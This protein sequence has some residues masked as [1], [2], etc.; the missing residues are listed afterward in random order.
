[1]LEGSL[2]PTRP[3]ATFTWSIGW[4]CVLL[5]CALAQVAGSIACKQ[6]ASSSEKVLRVGIL[7]PF[8][9]PAARTGEE[10]KDSVQMA[11]E[12]I[13]YRIG[14]YKVELRWIDEESDPQ[15]AVTNY[16][17]A[18][19][20][21]QIEVG[22]LNWHS[23]VAVAVMEVT[24]RY[25]IP[26]FFGM[27][28]TEV[29]NEKYRSDPARYSYWMAKGWPSPSKLTLAYVDALEDAIQHARWNL[30]AKTAAIWGEDTDWGRAFGQAIRDQ[31]QAHGWTIVAEEYFPLGETDFY[32][33]LLKF[34][35]ERVALLAGTST[36]PSS[37]S[38]FIKQTREV[39]L[40]SLIVADGLGWV[41]EW[42]SLTGDASDY[43]LDQIPGWMTPKAK[44]FAADFESRWG[45]KPSPAVAG[46]SYDYTNFFICVA[47]R[48]LEKYGRLDRNTFYRVGR[49][50]VM[51]GSLTY[52]EGVVMREYRYT[53][54]TAPDPVVGQGKYIFPVR[55]YEHGASRVIW[56]G[57]W[58]EADLELR[59]R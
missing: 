41:G 34:K 19:V 58:K 33:L 52:S 24:A 12:A 11:F 15:K 20:R 17:E 57:P 16:L 50:D 26:H 56:P 46:L 8:T 54:E 47:R 29:V 51:T 14:N 38:S 3:R 53:R 6:N 55:Q 30:P 35:V 23:S 1:M 45:L 7:G 59:Q 9:G 25:R 13:G 36:A 27:A 49:D 40:Q 37:L 22:C 44:Q 32:P 42:Y 5:A 43:V 48:A 18:V 2:V 10:F 4:R 21:D 39:G 28:A 31:L